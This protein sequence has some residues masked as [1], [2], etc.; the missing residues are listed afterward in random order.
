[1]VLIVFD[2]VVGQLNSLKYLKVAYSVMYL[3]VCVLFSL[4]HYVKY[5]SSSYAGQLIS[6]TSLN[7]TSLRTLAHSRGLTVHS[8]SER[9]NL[10]E[11]ISFSG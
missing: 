4:V 6:L 10:E 1:M 8:Q 11:V 2:R 3:L 9:S 5:S 7:L